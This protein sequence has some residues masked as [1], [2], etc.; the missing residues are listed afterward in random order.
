MSNKKHLS[1]FIAG[2]VDAKLNILEDVTA[3]ESAKIAEFLSI[4]NGGFSSNA[5][6]MLRNI[7]P[8]IE[9]HFIK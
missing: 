1:V 7:F 3:Y 4:M 6:D 8:I 5:H 2:I 9:R